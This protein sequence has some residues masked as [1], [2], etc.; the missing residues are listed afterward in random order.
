MRRLLAALMDADDALWAG[1]LARRSKVT[2]GSTYAMLRMLTD[3][4]W[5]TVQ[6]GPAL[7]GGGPARHLYQLTPA[8]CERAA[9]TLKED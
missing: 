2:F 9:E 1:D 4:G 3:R 5:V 7:R 8:A 6:P